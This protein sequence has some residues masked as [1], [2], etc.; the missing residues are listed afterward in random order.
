MAHS[1]VAEA[2]KLLDKEIRALNHGFVRLV[3]YMGSDDRIIQAARVS[4]G[5]GTKTVRQD[6]GLINYLMSHAHTSPFE[7]VVLTFHCK[8]PIF[9]ARQWVRHRTARLNEIS[10]RY[11]VMKDEFYVPEPSE[12][13]YQDVKNKQ[14]SA[15]A[16]PIAEALVIIKD[17]ENGQKRDYAHY[18]RLLDMGVSREVARVCLP[19]SLYTEWYWQ[20][21]LHNLYHFMW[22]RL[23]SHA[24]K[25][26]RVFGEALATCAKAVAPMAWG[27]FEEFKLFAVT[28]SRSEMHEIKARLS[29]RASILEGHNLEE[30]E[31]K[32]AKKLE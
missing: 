19:L 13:C 20:M 25:Q 17:F 16:L 15:S 4:Y 30:F 27:A 10:G 31:A 5:S 12:I 18:K 7:Q 2:E 29:G 21:D 14:G 1:I 8:M 22:L 3:D 32:L 6:Q 23:D 11:S 26:I 28:F 9:V 24:Q